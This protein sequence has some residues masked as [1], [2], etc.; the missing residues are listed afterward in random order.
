[1]LLAGLLVRSRAFSAGVTTA[2]VFRLLSGVFVL[3]WTLFMQA[4]LGMSPGQAAVGFVAASLGEMGG[5]RVGA[6]LAARY[7]RRA[8]QTGALLAWRWAPH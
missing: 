8:P 6:M 3:I 5:A 1:M 4:G 2:R 7:G